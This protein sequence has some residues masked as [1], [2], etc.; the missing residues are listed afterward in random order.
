MHL[1]GNNAL[2]ERIPMRIMRIIRMYNK[3][4]FSNPIFRANIFPHLETMAAKAAAEGEETL[5]AAVMV[6]AQSFK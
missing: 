3:Y 5:R 2:G 6:D 4:S 1:I